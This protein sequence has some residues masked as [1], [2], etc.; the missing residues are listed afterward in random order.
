MLAY[1][2]IREGTKWTDVFRLVPG[3]TVTIGRA[4]TNQIVIKDE[5]CSRNHAEI[6]QTSGNWTL[7]DL[8]SR[9][10]TVVGREPIR[11]DR[12][13]APGDVVRI[14]HCQLAFVHDLSKAFVDV[15]DETI[16]GRETVTGTVVAG[17]SDSHILDSETFEP[18]TITHR[19]GHT[20]F[21]ERQPSVDAAT[22]KVGRA[23][24]QLCRLAFELANQN[25]AISVANMA[26]D[27]LFEGTNVDAGAVL[28]LATQAQNDEPTV[29]DMQVVASRTDVESSYRRVSGFLASMV[30][31]DGEAVL[32]R[33]IQ[34]DSAL[35]IR[36]SQGVFLA[37]S[38]ICAPIRQDARVIGLAHLYCTDSARTLDA[39]DLEFTLSTLR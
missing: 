33:N 6:F 7:R 17:I 13:L 4:S 28:L 32:A 35:G 1:L 3:R 31:R 11:G 23:A 39:D 9:N 20:R 37:T 34:G 19:R 16:D 26:L 25:T 22:P 29:D 10:G 8:D 12:T 24:T 18:T 27:G 38:V 14:A 5:R 36:D 30:L 15:D 21:L 2:V